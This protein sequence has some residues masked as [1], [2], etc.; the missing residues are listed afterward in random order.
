[1]DTSALIEA[2]EAE[3][4]R[5]NRNPETVTRRAVGA[6]QLYK[7]LKSGGTCTLEV[8]NRLM[9]YISEAK[10]KPSQREDAA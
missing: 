8:A 6:S 10:R 1:M 7:R 5:I 2:I 3:A 9:A 4:A